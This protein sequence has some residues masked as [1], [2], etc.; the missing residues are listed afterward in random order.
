VAT[1]LC[2]FIMK[3]TCFQYFVY[4]LHKGIALSALMLLVG[5]LEGEG[6]GVVICLG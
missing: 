4:V 3:V 6:A 5:Q 1:E 2:V